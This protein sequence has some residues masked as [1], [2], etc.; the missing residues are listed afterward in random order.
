MQ[1]SQYSVPQQG[2]LTA[3]RKSLLS[4]GQTKEG[5]VGFLSRTSAAVN[6]VA[7]DACFCHDA[8]NVGKVE[9]PKCQEI[10]EQIGLGNDIAAFWGD[11]DSLR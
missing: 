8:L 4:I 1:S 10:H 2:V 5:S 11:H 6:A 3:S 9:H 7:R